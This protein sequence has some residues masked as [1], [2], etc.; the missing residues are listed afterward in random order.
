MSVDEAKVYLEKIVEEK[1]YPVELKIE[2]GED[3]KKRL[4]AMYNWDDKGTLSI[5]TRLDEVFKENEEISKDRLDE[6]LKDF[7]KIGKQF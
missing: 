4:F 5:N 2:I 7:V 6:W 3:E 1:G